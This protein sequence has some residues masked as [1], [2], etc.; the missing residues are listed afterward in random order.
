MPA[1]SR[2]LK[3]GPPLYDH[4]RPMLTGVPI[5]KKHPNSIWAVIPAENSPSE[6]KS[7]PNAA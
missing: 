7:S 4:V 2:R 1:A 5:Q 3:E 6:K